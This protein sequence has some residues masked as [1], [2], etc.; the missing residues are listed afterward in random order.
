MSQE[1]LLESDILVILFSFLIWPCMRI[2]DFQR[3]RYL[4]AFALV[5][6]FI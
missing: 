6:D 2:Y 3:A 4:V 5:I 1:C